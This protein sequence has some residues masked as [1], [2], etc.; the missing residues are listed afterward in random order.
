MAASVT[1][2]SSEI[3]C[4]EAWITPLSNGHL[5]CDICDTY[6]CKHIQA[7]VTRN[8]DSP[9]IFW[10]AELPS[11]RIAVPMMPTTNQWAEVTLEPAVELRSLSYEVI[12]PETDARTGDP[13]LHFLGY[14]H[15]GEG[16]M[17]LRSM[18]YDWFRGH[19]DVEN[20]ECKSRG[21]KLTQQNRWI[22]D[23]ADPQR[24]AAQLWSVWTTGT[25]LGCSFTTDGIDDLIPD[26]DRRM[27]GTR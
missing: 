6:W 15:P 2:E 10:N 4:G 23:L 26:D 24:S 18:I 14:I 8:E 22:T 21:H 16:R 20:L 27:P 12:L 1:Q 17:I 5:K 3:V 19:V 11:R 25:C 9:S 7:V 13:E